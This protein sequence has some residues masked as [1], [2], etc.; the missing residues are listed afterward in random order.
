MVMQLIFGK[1]LF[2]G[3]NACYETMKRIIKLCGDLNTNN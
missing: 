3:D 2:E 1:N